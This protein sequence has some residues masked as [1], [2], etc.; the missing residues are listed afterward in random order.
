MPRDLAY[1][2]LHL[3]LMEIIERGAETQERSHAL[4]QAH[5][6]LDADVRASLTAVRAQRAQMRAAREQARRLQSDN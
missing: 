4:V 5:Q 1:G 2:S 6:D 3:R